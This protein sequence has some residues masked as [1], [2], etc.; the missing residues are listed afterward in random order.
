MLV[1]QDPTDPQSTC[2]LES[3]LDAFRSASRVVGTFAFAS[4]T[5]VRRLTEAEEFTAVAR[6]RPVELVVGVDAVT[7]ERALDALAAVAGAWPNVSAKAFLNPHPEHLYH[8]KFCWTK[9]A[10]GGR[11]IAGSGNLTEG[12]LLDH[13]EGYAV[14]SLDAAGVGAVEE[15]WNAWTARHDAHLVALDNAE[16]RRRARENT[17]MA[18]EGDLPTLHAGGGAAP[19]VRP[20]VRPPFPDDARVLIAEIP[21]AKNRWKQA[22]F[23]KEDFEGFFGAR[24]DEQRRFFFGHVLPDGSIAPNSKSHPSVVVGSDNY[25]FEL[26]AASGLDYPEEGRPIGVFIRVANRNFLYRLL[27]PGDPSYAIAEG[28]LTARKGPARPKKMRQERTDVN[29]LR[30][31]WPDAPFWRLLNE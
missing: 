31:T 15:A 14:E 30:A 11:L 6:R 16:V 8:P 20:P 25:R 13:W 27:M 29:D 7:N 3:L 28:V 5:G 10:A 4:A 9:N 17:V 12:G 24:V 19:V 26:D 22:N 23:V 21:R 18:P 1:I 2:L